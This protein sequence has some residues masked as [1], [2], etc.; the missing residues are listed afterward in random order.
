MFI[1]TSIKHI[2]QNNKKQSKY[3]ALLTSQNN[4]QQ[5]EYVDSFSKAFPIF[6]VNGGM[7]I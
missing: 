4:I 1:Y 6:I 3:Q 5:H 2:F 7:W